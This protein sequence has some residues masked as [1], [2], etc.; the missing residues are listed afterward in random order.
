MYNLH[1]KSNNKSNC[2]EHFTTNK[3][4]TSKQNKMGLRRRRN[5]EIIG[6]FTIIVEAK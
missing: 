2:I 3:Q 4:I 5:K 6:F 1:L